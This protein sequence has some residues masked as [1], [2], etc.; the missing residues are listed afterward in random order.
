M[1]LFRCDPIFVGFYP[2]LFFGL[3]QL[4]LQVQLLLLLWLLLLFIV[5]GLTRTKIDNYCLHNI[6]ISRQG[7]LCA[8]CVSGSV[9]TRPLTRCCS[10]FIFRSNTLCAQCLVLFVNKITVFV[11]KKKKKKKDTVAFHSPPLVLSLSLYVYSMHKLSVW[12]LYVPP[13]KRQQRSWS[14]QRK[15][16]HPIYLSWV[17][18]DTACL[19]SGKK[20]LVSVSV[21]VCVCARTINKHR[22]IKYAGFMGPNAIYHIWIETIA[23]FNVYKIYAKC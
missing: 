10:P 13:I 15:I 3:W 8:G 20:L 22:S 23:Y 9:S 6:T 12:F 21:R 18:R 17:S 1:R 5:V 16:R 2:Q 4:L 19:H 14:R 11:A 7:C